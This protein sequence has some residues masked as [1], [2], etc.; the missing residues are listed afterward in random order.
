[1][2]RIDNVE[3][4]CRIPEVAAS[5]FVLFWDKDTELCRLLER[6]GVRCFNSAHT[7]ATCDDKWLTCVALDGVEGV[8]QPKTI[9]VPFSYGFAGIWEETGFAE[10][11]F[12]ELGSPVVVK[13]RHGSFGAQVHLADGKDELNGILDELLGR[14]A[15]CQQYISTSEGRDIRVQIAGGEFVAAMERGARPGDFRSNITNGGSATPLD[16]TKEQIDMA[17]AAAAAVKAD[18]A[19]VDLMFGESGPVVCEINSNAHFVNLE[20]TTRI[21][22]AE[23]LIA[24]ISEEVGRESMAGLR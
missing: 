16:P 4:A 18:F 20:N 6:R 3:C 15:I 13:E 19:G 24:V 23:K 17:I 14:P 2:K 10:H 21:D 1:M 8:I 22:V 11:V 12:E 5:D 9:L 7:I